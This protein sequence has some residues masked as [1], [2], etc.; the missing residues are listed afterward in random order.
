MHLIESQALCTGLKIGKPFIHEHFIPLPFDG[1]FISFQPFS[2]YD[3][4][5]YAYWKDV[6]DIIYPSLLKNSIRIVQLGIKGEPRVSG[7]YDLR[8]K[9]T[10]KQAAY[11]IKQGVLHVG[12][13]S[14]GVHMASGFGKKIVALYNIMKPSECGPFWSD[15]KDISII[16]P[17]RE[18]RENPSYSSK[19]DPKTIN[20]IPSEK[21]AKEISKM[22]GLKI[23]YPYRTLYSGEHYGNKK[24]ELIPHSW[25]ENVDSLNI[26]AVIVR[27]DL[28]FNETVLEEQVKR[29]PCGI[30]T[31]KPLNIKILEMYK[32][33]LKEFVFLITEDFDH[34]RDSSF[35]DEV[36]ELG[37]KINL[38]TFLKEEDLNKFKLKVLDYGPI[39]RRKQ[40][41]REEIK[42][43]EG[44]NTEDL[45]FKS[46]SFTVRKDLIYASKDDSFEST[47]V[48]NLNY[49]DPMPLI[50]SEAF[51]SESDYF[52]ILEKT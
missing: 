10:L 12:T 19:E 26:D 5:N 11:I 24:V 28:E 17:E 35:L 39:Y 22:L 46:S 7:C 27:M 13:D 8:G 37:I 49:N 51:W 29:C 43:L 6:I 45:F 30:V 23:D 16:E 15:E 40:K 33:R 2:K 3:S 25:V 42:E 41:R 48:N 21:I 52:S 32:P 31:D 50:D 20:T 36:K 38:M 44:K 1:E 34:K 47:P 9:T 18:E 4:K 14:F